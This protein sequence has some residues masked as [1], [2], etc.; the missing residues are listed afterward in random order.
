MAI[1]YA[2]DAIPESVSTPPLP[3]EMAIGDVLIVT[4][5]IISV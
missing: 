3:W 5:V 1:E 4:A 2:T